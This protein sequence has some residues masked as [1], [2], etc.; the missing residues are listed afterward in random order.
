MHLAGRELDLQGKP[1]LVDPQVQLGRQ[2]STTSTDTSASTLFFWAAACWCT[3]TELESIIC[4]FPPLASWAV[5][6]API[7]LSH[8]PAFRQRLKRL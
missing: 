1:V 2:S 3:R 7:S 8:T 6:I 4:I 5:M